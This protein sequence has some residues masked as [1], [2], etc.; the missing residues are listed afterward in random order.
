M[1]CGCGLATFAVPLL[2]KYEARVTRL[3]VRPRLDHDQLSGVAYFMGE[4][5]D[6][7][8]L[9]GFFRAGWWTGRLAEGVLLSW[10]GGVRVGG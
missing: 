8:V 10:S 3:A 9:G 4:L 6:E 1:L 7:A 5:R 2:D